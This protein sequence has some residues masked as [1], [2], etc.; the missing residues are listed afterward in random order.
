LLE[1]NKPYLYKDLCEVLGLPRLSGGSQTNQIRKLSKQY[2]LVKKNR[3]YIIKGEFDPLERATR[4]KYKQHRLFI[5]PMLYCLLEK[6]PTNVL[7]TDMKQL[8][9]SLNVINERFFDAKWKLDKVDLELTGDCNGDLSIFMTE[10][11]PML[12]KIVKDVLKE[13][14]EQFLIKVNMIPKFARI[15]RRDGK[16]YTHIYEVN[17]EHEYPIFLEA[18][19][20]ALTHFKCKSIKELGYFRQREYKHYVENI[21]KDRLNVKYFYYEY[22]I[23][24]NT[25]GLRDAIN[26]DYNEFANEF[27]KHIMEYVKKSKRGHLKEIPTNKKEIY[28]DTLIKSTL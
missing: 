23:I 28:I 26:E 11:E 25:D 3:Y 8:M 10:T 6:S 15:E 7:R 27:N 9:L 17:K 13:M 18:N 4:A 19:R 14:E 20:Q 2:D 22:E 21:L 16:Y 5:E 12:R 24:L 1:Y